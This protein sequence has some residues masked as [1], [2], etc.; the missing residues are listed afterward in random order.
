VS[1]ACAFIYL[2]R[3]IIMINNRDKITWYFYNIVK[4]IINFFSAHFFHQDFY[5]LRC[6]SY[7][8]LTNNSPHETWL[9][10]GFCTKAYVES[11]QKTLIISSLGKNFIRKHLLHYHWSA[12]KKLN[13]TLPIC[14][15]NLQA[16][17]ICY[18]I[19]WVN[20]NSIGLEWGQLKGL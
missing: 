10:R 4:Y 3:N 12:A 6:H 13:K 2:K 18:Y 11:K 5:Y 15:I 7:L 9:S 20:K 19:L 8:W 17:N 1:E 16:Q 14:M